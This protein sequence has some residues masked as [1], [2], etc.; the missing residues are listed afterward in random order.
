MIHLVDDADVSSGLPLV[1]ASLGVFGAFEP[2]ELSDLLGVEGKMARRGDARPGG[3]IEGEDSWTFR[4]AEEPS[5]DWEG[6]LR[7]ALAA[8]EGREE[9]FARFCD[10]RQLERQVALIAKMAA[11]PPEGTADAP[12]GTISSD[13]VK[14]LASLGCALDIDLYCWCSDEH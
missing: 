10:D 7:R 11:P 2:D 8:T 9:Q 4:T 13:L 14:R 5:F 6:H 1:S 3:R 12:I